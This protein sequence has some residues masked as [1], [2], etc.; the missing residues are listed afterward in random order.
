MKAI[1]QYSFYRAVRIIIFICLFLLVA[2]AMHRT[3]LTSDVVIFSDFTPVG[4]AVGALYY[5]LVLCL[6]VT[7]EKMTS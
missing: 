3:C 1:S 4:C 6:A 2:Y 5:L 7:V